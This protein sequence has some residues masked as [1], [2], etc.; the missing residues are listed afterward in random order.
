M[1]PAQ[2]FVLACE[3]YR[4]PQHWRWVLRDGR[5]NFLADHEV[6][7]DP[8]CSEYD[9]VIDLRGYLESHAAPDRWRADHARLLAEFG[10]WLGANVLGKAIGDK[11]RAPRVPLTVRVEVPAP[12]ACLLAVPLEL[13]HAGGKPL[14]LGGISLVSLVKG[15]GDGTAPE[16]ET[17][18]DRLRMLA[19][20]SLPTQ[21][22]AL[23]LR[24]ERHA[25]TRL[26]SEIAQTRGAA[27]ELR[28]L[29]YGASRSALKDALEEADGWDLIHF[30]GHGERGVL[31][32]EQDDGSNDIITTEAL[33]DLLAPARGRLKFATLSAC[34]SAAAT[35]AETRAWLGLPAADAREAPAA[36]TGSDTVL[37][38]LARALANE[39]GCAVLAMRYPVGDQFAIDLA[40]GLFRHL[41]ENRQPLPRAL[42]MALSQAV[43]EAPPLSVATPALFG[44]AALALTLA[45]P[46]QQAPPP[47]YTE[48]SAFPDEPERFVGR[49]GALAR[50]TRALAP[51]SG[52]AGVLFCGMAGAGKTAAALELAYRYQPT[53]LQPPS[54]FR[55]FVWYKAPDQRADGAGADIGRALVDLALA[56]E[57]QIAGWEMVHLVDS[58]QHFATLL[59][60]LT[61]LCRQR[62]ILF[63]LDNLESLLTADGRWRDQR[64]AKL[65]ATLAAA[66]GFSRLVLTSRTRPADLPASL[67]LEAM[68][69]LPLD[70]AL[71]LAREL[72][73]LG[74]LL[75]AGEA[76]NTAASRALVLRTLE[77]VQGH[78]K[79]IELA[80]HLAA[81]PEAL[82]RQLAGSEDL[83]AAGDASRLGAFFA[84]GEAAVGDD[85][86]LTVLAGWTRSIAAT[87]PAAAARLF[88]V[89]CGMEDGDRRQDLL[90]LAWPKLWQA[91]GQAGDAP[92]LD[93]LI[94]AL[95]ACGL[96]AVEARENQPATY[97]LHPGV[98]AAGKPA[99]ARQ[100]MLDRV[101]ASMHRAIVD[102]ALEQEG[103]GTGPWIVAHGLAAAP[104]LAR[105]H[106]WDALAWILQEVIHRD[107]SPATLALVLPPL[108]LAA[109]GSGALAA[110]GALAKALRRAGRLSEAE[111]LMRALIADA[112]AGGAFWQAL[113]TASDLS[114]LLRATGRAEEAL[115][116]VARK[117]EFTTRA[118]LG[119]WTMIS[120]DCQ[121]L[122]ALNALGRWEDVLTEVAALR[123][124]MDALPESG[125]G[126]EAAYPWGVRETTL[127][128]GLSAAVM[129]KRWQEC[130]D[131][132]S[133]VAASE[134][135]RGASALQIAGTRFNDYA[136]LLRLRRYGEAQVLLEACRRTFEAAGDVAVLGKVFS[137][138]ADLA[139]ERGHLPQALA[140]EKTALRY[141]YSSGDP[142]TVTIS[143]FNLA[144]YLSRTAAPAQAILAHRLAATL[145]CLQTGDGKLAQYFAALAED[146]A[147]F[148]DAQPPA[149]FAALGAEVDQVEGVRFAQLFARLPAPF[150]NGDAALA[151]VLALASEQPG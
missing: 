83:W 104:Y 144:S 100:E 36:A 99:P 12:A 86:Y 26:I 62:S 105:Q 14:A 109:E 22:T 132:N 102:Q 108:R 147:R 20:F 16:P 73:N 134:A 15:E 7:L 116:L 90:G 42:A 119:P 120:T 111:A 122:Q 78:P 43:P 10:R 8:A 124:R 110:R 31:L 115:E 88:E 17:V 40:A 4:N 29:Q 34:W 84:D 19:L 93:A 50:A 64:W 141:K 25:L 149:T 103:A 27:I 65:I 76:S 151:H 130:L 69:A 80:D 87:L 56:M 117:K 135:A 92:A 82:R 131:L 13:A 6:H 72:P 61:A 39:L 146:L 47:L 54:R 63:V 51:N 37:P 97:R 49:T 106:A 85:G 127:N 32:L 81:N 89:V 114:N 95:A 96:I 150:G 140:H 94:T 9:G 35:I 24:R 52:Q 67:R 30:S 148:H 126:E 33:L 38:S 79:L 91:L 74:R 23:A 59:P 2:P 107:Q 137:A 44:A 123:T 55:H 101:M 125:T 46:A 71:L 98:A 112:E 113:A 21:A 118:G 121:R 58:D 145:I 3:D 142:D 28:V 11:L 128:T 41:F 133:A 77:I 75:T 66:G 57:Q 70:E 1:A 45:P 139:D 143:H 138:L 48:M 129:L 53:P 136:P 18:G 60:R 68:H 5:G